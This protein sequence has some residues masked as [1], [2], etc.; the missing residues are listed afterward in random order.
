VRETTFKHYGV[1]FSQQDPEVREKSRL[2][3]LKKYGVENGGG[4]KQAQEKIYQTKKARHTFS[5][6]KVEVEFKEWL[7]E[8]F[9]KDNVMYQYKDDKRYPFN[10]DFYVK[11]LDLFIEVQGFASHQSH[12]YDQ[13]SQEDQEHLA[14]LESKATSHPM[15]KTFI[16]VWTTIDPLK[17]KTARENNLNFIEIFSSKNQDCI[18]AVEDY[19]SASSYK[20]RQSI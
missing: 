6:S 13:S 10:C 16:E 15:Y 7:E 2:T 17:R 11:P 12:P 20:E 4:S 18:K 8:K 9:G 19:L 14:F 5:S 1:E 3:N